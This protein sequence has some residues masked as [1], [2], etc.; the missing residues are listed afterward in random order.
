VFRRTRRRRCRHDRPLAIK[1][2]LRQPGTRTLLAE[3]RDGA[4]IAAVMPMWALGEPGVSGLTD[5]KSSATSSVLVAPSHR[6]K[7]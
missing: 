1:R 3:T 5:Q 6:W 2:L 7:D 4:L